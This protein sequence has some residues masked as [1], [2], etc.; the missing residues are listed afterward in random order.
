MQLVKK[1][2]PAGLLFMVYL[3]Y[4]GA[5]RFFVEFLR[6]NPRFV[7]GLSEAQLIAAAM[8]IAGIIGYA[9]VSGTKAGESAPR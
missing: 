3:I 1:A 8:I 6:L 7:F 9:M 4:S 5:A 2:R